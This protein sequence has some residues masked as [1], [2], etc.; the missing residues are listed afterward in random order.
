[1]NTLAKALVVGVTILACLT[2]GAVAAT[3]SNIDK[4][5]D[6]AVKQETAKLAAQRSQKQAVVEREVAQDDRDQK[7]R[8]VKDLRDQLDELV[9]E[10]KAIVASYKLDLEK[11]DAQVI[12]LEGRIAENAL[13]LKNNSITIKQ[14]DVELRTLRVTKLDLKK[15]LF[16]LQK[17]LR[18]EIAERSKFERLSRELKEQTVALGEELRELSQV[19]SKGAVQGEHATVALEQEIKGKVTVVKGTFVQLNVGKS[20]GLR[21]GAQLTVYKGDTFRATIKIVDL[22]ERSSVGEILV[23]GE[24]GGKIQVN[25]SVMN[26]SK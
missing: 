20:D 13:A 1:L 2:L 12:K 14:D 15:R 21:K 5:K 9:G 24:Q 19:A 23:K 8:Q 22:E 7:V 16:D 3:F 10:K 17:T 26:L 4:I 6:Y 11:R 25:D 18:E